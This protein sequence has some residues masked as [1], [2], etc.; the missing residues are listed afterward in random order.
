MKSYHH[1]DISLI[2]VDSILTNKIDVGRS[3]YL[4][5]VVISCKHPS[6]P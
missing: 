1:F 6:H 4:L 5:A 2:A 3:P